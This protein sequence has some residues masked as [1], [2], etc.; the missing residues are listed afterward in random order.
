MKPES[1]EEIMERLKRDAR[2]GAVFGGIWSAA[3]V[4]LFAFVAFGTDWTVILRGPA[5]VLLAISVIQIPFSVSA[6]S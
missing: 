6:F 4:F 3:K 1:T 2:R 5:L